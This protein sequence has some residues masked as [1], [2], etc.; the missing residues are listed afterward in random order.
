MKTQKQSWP[1]PRFM[2]GNDPS[3]FIFHLA[4]LGYGDHT[5]LDRPFF[6]WGEW[7]NVYTM[8]IQQE[9][10]WHE[11]GWIQPKCLISVQ[12]LA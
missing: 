3:S 9:M 10:T 6:L 7:M 2:S 11:H 8:I 4:K 12:S 1:K 5:H